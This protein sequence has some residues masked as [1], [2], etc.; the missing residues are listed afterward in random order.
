MYLAVAVYAASVEGEDVE[1]G[2]GRMA[3]QKVYVALLA[4]LVTALRKQADVIRAVRR[5][6]GHTVLLHRSVLPQKWSTLFCMTL[7]AG[8]IDGTSLKHLRA[9]APVRVVAGVAIN[10]HDPILCAEEMR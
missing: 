8:L 3:R 2:D 6:A 1:P 9:F 10:F 7:I 4:E 5:M